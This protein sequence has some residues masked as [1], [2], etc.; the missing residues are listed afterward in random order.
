MKSVGLLS[1]QQKPL[2]SMNS[3][4]VIMWGV[5]RLLLLANTALS[6]EGSLSFRTD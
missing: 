3:V 5:K 6:H 2:E 1:Y 4:V